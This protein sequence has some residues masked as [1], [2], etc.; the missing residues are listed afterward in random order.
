MTPGPVG[1]GVMT[2]PTRNDGYAVWGTDSGWG[3]TTVVRG[4]TD[5]Q[6][7]MKL[8][9]GTLLISIL[10]GYLIGGRMSNLGHLRIRWA[11]LAIV[12]FAM[13]IVNPPGRWPLAMLLASFVLLS[14]FAVANLKTVGF[15]L[16]LV[17]V[18]L[19]F[20]VIGANG[21]MP[22]SEQALIA[23]GQADTVSDLTNDADSYV[24]HHL[25][26]EDDVLL[27]LGDVIAVPSPIAQA[28]SVGDIFTYGG[29][30]VV[31]AAGMRRRETDVAVGQE[32]QRV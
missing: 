16:V 15:P 9:A 25:A 29:V 22:V 31:I 14:L 7:Q 21:G 5:T 30:C 20:I 10:A 17:G 6:E 1:P 18:A 28:I 12:G 3:S 19:N 4:R 24:K 11:P 32:V 2:S 8:I 23:S 13:Q 26:D 27:F